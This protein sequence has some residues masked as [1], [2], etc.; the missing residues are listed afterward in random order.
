MFKYTLQVQ[1]ARQELINFS[2]D[3]TRQQGKHSEYASVLLFLASDNLFVRHLLRYY[4]YYCNIV[5]SW[6]VFML[7]VTH[8]SQLILEF[9]IVFTIDNLFEMF[10]GAFLVVCVS[11]SFKLS[12]SVRYHEKEPAKFWYVDI[13]SGSV[14]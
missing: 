7:E 13:T 4:T 2:S 3:Y 10:S 9:N 14:S 5:T 12:R 6:S 11:G 1:Y 8:N